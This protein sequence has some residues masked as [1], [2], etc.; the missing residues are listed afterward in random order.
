MANSRQDIYLL[1]SP[2]ISVLDVWLPLLKQIRSSNPSARIHILITRIAVV[3]Q[4][5]TTNILIT[6][7]A[8]LVD[9]V[10]LQLR[11]TSY[12]RFTSI[13]H[14]SSTWL[15]SFRLR[16]LLLILTRCRIKNFPQQ[17]SLPKLIYSLLPLSAFDFSLQSNDILL[18]DISEQAKTY[19][20]ALFSTIPRSVQKFSLYHGI[21]INISPQ[22]DL[23]RLVNVDNLTTLLYS[24]LEV[25]FYNNRSRLAESE[26]TVVGIPRHDRRWVQHLLD[27]SSTS[28]HLPPKYVVLY[29]RPPSDYLPVKQRIQYIRS[30]YNICKAYHFHLLIKL[31]P[32][33]A[34][35]TDYYNTLGHPSKSNNWSFTS[36]H[37]LFLSK[38]ASL[39]IMFYSNICIDTAYLHQPS[40]ELLN[41]S[42]INKYD[43]ETSLRDS[44]G[45]PCFSYRYHGLIHGVSTLD[46]FYHS[47][48]AAIANPVRFS[49]PYHSRY[50]QLFP[51][52]KN[53]PLPSLAHMILG[54]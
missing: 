28:C 17:S 15:S 46:S 30:I 2:G 49:K 40:I 5:D 20:Y 23:S 26:L 29:S 53:I 45:D 11:D 48:D 24:E 12:C 16:L 19:N 33:E 39:S 44:H 18:H 8:N 22:P 41:L 42:G 27:T 51:S 21:D 38:H 10:L 54:Q 3:Q 1:C 34:S 14:L 25:S 52:P 4:I 31:H 35:S 43:N 9:S 32:K 47:F 13:T 50:H 37:P 36:L 6:E 7:S